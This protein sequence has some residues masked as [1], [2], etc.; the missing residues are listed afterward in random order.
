MASAQEIATV[1]NQ[2]KKM[3][4]NMI[5][6]SK[7]TATNLGSQSSTVANF[8]NSTTG[9]VKFYKFFDW[10]GKVVGTGYPPAVQSQGAGQFIHEGE[11]EK[12]S[13]GAVVYSGVNKQG[14]SCGWL[15]AWSA[16]TNVGPDSPNKVFVECGPIAKFDTIIWSTIEAKLDVSDS[17]VNTSDD[18]TATNVSAAINA[19]GNDAVI[20]A[21]FGVTN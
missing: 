7:K 1:N 11:S 3:L 17:T 21:V 10:S 4:D 19:G 2:Q 16:P 18:T 20:G 5:E 9:E 13:K 15:F 14:V 8:S 12:G 6:K